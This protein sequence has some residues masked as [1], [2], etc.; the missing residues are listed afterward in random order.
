MFRL[1]S[2]IFSMA[3]TALMGAAVIVV[4]TLGHVTLP[5]ILIAAVVGLLAAVPVSWFVARQISG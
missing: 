3:A 5:A 4:L 1:M 2:I